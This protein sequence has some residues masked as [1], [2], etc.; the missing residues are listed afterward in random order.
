M[1]QLP[2]KNIAFVF[3]DQAGANAC[4]AL[5]KMSKGKTRISLYTNRNY[6]GNTQQVVYT[7]G[8]P[9]LDKVET[10]FLGTSHPVSS[11]Y[12]ELN[13][14]KKAKQKNIYTISFI[15]HWI[16][17]KL[18]FTD[19]NGELI[20]PNEIW[21]V[22]E[23]AKQLA[24]EEGLPAPL[25]KVSGNPYHYYLK[26]Q[27]RPVWK[28][29]SYLSSFNIT[30]N[31]FHIV[32]AP[33]PL[34]L[35]NSKEMAGFS[36]QEALHDILDVISDFRDKDLYLVVKCHPLQPEE[37]LEK[38]INKTKSSYVSLIK[39]ADPLELINTADVVVGFYSNFLLDAKAM[40][41]KVVRYFPGK[42]E[43]DLLSHDSS[44]LK[45]KDKAS[46]HHHLKNLIYG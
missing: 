45:I 21:V 43:A 37:I 29:K 44:L 20:F 14:L 32:F 9:S 30:P 31:A 6:Y 38:E 12:F 13:C 4:T 5:A 26:H 19:G 17:F 22:D 34:S 7:D 27:W 8:Q 1:L 35:R 28:G 39:N 24:V 40:G 23:K 36:E 16:N 41:K 3:S 25:I 33:D 10:V 46:L 11:D 2:G 15:D 42:E 18:R